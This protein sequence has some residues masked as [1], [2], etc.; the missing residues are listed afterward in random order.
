MGNRPSAKFAQKQRA[1]TIAAETNAAHRQTRDGFQ[2]GAAALGFGGGS[3]QDSSTYRVGFHTR[4]R[5]VLEAAYRGNWICRTVVDCVA[6]DM[7]RAG[8]TINTDGLKPDEQEKLQKAMQRLKIWTVLCDGMRWGRLYGGAVV[9]IMIKGQS[10]SQP[11][12]MAT[13]SKG[14]FAGLIALDRWQV[15]PSLNDHVT[16]LGPDLG[17]PKY[18]E[19]NQGAQALPGQKIHYTRLFRMEGDPIPYF[20]RLTEMG[21]GCSVLEALWDRLIAYD[22]TTEGA[23]QLVYKAHLRVFS[24]EGLREIMLNPKAFEGLKKQVEFMRQTQ[25]NEGVTMI[26][27]NDEF[28]PHSYTFAGLP[29]LMLQFAQQISGGSQI[30]MVRLYGQSPAGLNSTGESDLR[31]YYD[32]VSRSQATDLAG[33][34]DTVF[35]LLAL[36]ELGKELPD[37][38]AYNWNPLWQLRAEEKANIA[39]I[40]TE[41]IKAASDACLVPDAVAMRELRQMSQS[42]GIFSHISDEDIDNADQDPPE[43]EPTQTAPGVPAEPGQ[44]AKAGTVVPETT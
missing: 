40:T 26:D 36:S 17:R 35:E 18:Y 21:W 7:T 3:Q 25:S 13:V 33:P 30:P 22:S 42:T 14:T 8:V 43:P 31:T 19:V 12:D 10:M 2:N 32:N 29:D 27:K 37:G 11:L 4:N 39:K 41:T 20:Q 38:F 44:A 16:E 6:E 34:L 1:A 15:T 23:A 9:V 28:T 5:A 24:V